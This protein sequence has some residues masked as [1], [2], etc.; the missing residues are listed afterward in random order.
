MHQPQQARAVKSSLLASSVFH[1]PMIPTYRGHVTTRPVPVQV[2]TPKLA[3]NRWNTLDEDEKAS[4][5]PPCPAE[6]AATPALRASTSAEPPQAPEDADSS[7]ARLT[8][9]TPSASCT[10]ST[11][12]PLLPPVQHKGPSPGSPNCPTLRTLMAQSGVVTVSTGVRVLLAAAARQEGSTDGMLIA[13][14]E[15]H[16]VPGPVGSTQDPRSRGSSGTTQERR[17]RGSSGYTQDAPV[18]GSRGTTQDPAVQGPMGAAPADA[19]TALPEICLPMS[20]VT[21]QAVVLQVDT[22][23]TSSVTGGSRPVCPNVC[24]CGE[25]K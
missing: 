12:S 5:S 19:D 14:A 24:C 7:H 8:I 18:P 10:S 3:T 11:S 2:Q 20:S 1:V 4:Q 16:V 13:P 6:T 22:S 21:A 25:K 9:A 23:P 15:V 17:S